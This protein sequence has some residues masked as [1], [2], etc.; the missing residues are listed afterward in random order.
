VRVLWLNHK[1]PLSP[2][3]GGAERTILEVGS[4]LVRRGH[5]VMVLA[6]SWP[7][8]ASTD[9]VKGVTIRRYPGPILPHLIFPLLLRFGKPPDVVIDDLAHVAPWFSPHFTDAPGVVFF[10]H[11]HA[12][13][14]EGQVPWPA[15][16]ILGE[17]ERWYPQLY[18]TWTFVTESERG[19]ADLVH[20]GIPP[21]RIQRIPPGVD[22]EL[23]CP[24]S[25]TPQPS[26]IYFG[27]LRRY[28]NATDAVRLLRELIRRG[29]R[30]NLI[31][32]GTGPSL[33]AVMRE[34]RICGLEDLVTF[35]GRVPQARLAEVLKT[36]W[37]NVHLSRAEGWGYSAL[38]AASSGVPTVAYRV[39]GVTESVV[40]GSTGRLVDF[41]DLEGLAEG[42]MEILASR[43][44]WPMKCREHA[45]KFDWERTTASWEELLLRECQR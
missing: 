31:I 13:T 4:R 43:E 24:G 22:G 3:A 6:G 16:R 5:A 32:L 18:P 14:L 17:M 1:D 21:R 26:I 2:R 37:L 15:S 38:E 20:L 28:K 44:D 45:Q 39:P 41:G 10:R 42:A 27:G 9:K 36:A 19:M 34:V 7:G 33:P 30:A 12:R 35:L 8:A 29:V 23:F 25:K 11:L 40:D